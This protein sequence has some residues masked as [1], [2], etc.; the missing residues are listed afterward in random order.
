[1]GQ[2]REKRFVPPIIDSK[3]PPLIGHFICSLETSSDVVGLVVGWVQPGYL[4]REMGQ[5]LSAS[6]LAVRVYLGPSAA[7]LVDPRSQVHSE[8][9][10]PMV[11]AESAI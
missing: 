1:M 10:G 5:A 11:C 3:F 6:E 4:I 8:V 2:I 9:G 7:Q